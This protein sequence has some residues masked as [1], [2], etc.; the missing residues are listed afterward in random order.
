MPEQYSIRA[1]VVSAK[2]DAEGFA[3]T[4]NLWRTQTNDFWNGLVVNQ[5]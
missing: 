2:P 4:T 3:R 5:K 1:H